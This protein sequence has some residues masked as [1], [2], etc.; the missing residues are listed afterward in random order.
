[1]IQYSNVLA[2]DEITQLIDY[3]NSKEYSKENY[4]DTVHGHLLRYRNK[5]SEYEIA[6][7]AVRSIL[8]PKVLS[9]IGEHG[10]DGGM[11]LESHY[12]FGLHIDSWTDDI[13][14]GKKMHV[15]NQLFAN[16]SIMFPLVSS[17][18][19]NTVFFDYYSDTILDFPNEGNCQNTDFFINNIDLS[20]FTQSQRNFVA[21]KSISG[22]FEWEA[23]SVVVWPRNQLHCSGNFYNSGLIKTAIILFT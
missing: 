21:D 15:K 6:D 16:K 7:S 23:G 8:Y 2:P 13:F 12:P 11:L 22:V 9:I 14:P 17:K 1:M 5:H 4:K 20:H 3:F 19:F 18:K 10:I